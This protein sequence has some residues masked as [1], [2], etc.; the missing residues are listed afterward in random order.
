MGYLRHERFSSADFWAY[1]DAQSD[2]KMRERFA[3]VH[4][5]VP[6]AMISL[7]AIWG[8]KVELMD[9]PITDLHPLSSSAIGFLSLHNTKVSDLAPLRGMLLKQITFDETTVTDVSPLLDLP[10]LEA[11]MVT[12]RATN[13][14]VLRHHPTLQ[15][16]GW[17]GDWDAE[18]SRPKL[19]TAEFWQRY[20]TQKAAGK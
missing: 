2:P 8:L 20:D 19:T 14:E 9:K 6:E 16:L 1:R 13:L 18:H 5:A 7:S 3:Q 17:E 11:A 15:Y 12:Q 4:A 10:I